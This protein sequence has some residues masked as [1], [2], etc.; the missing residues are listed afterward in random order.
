MLPIIDKDEPVITPAINPLAIVLR[1]KPSE[2]ICVFACCK[3]YSE[4]N[5]D[6]AAAPTVT[7]VASNL[8]TLIVSLTAKALL[9]VLIATKPLAANLP[10]PTPVAIPTGSVPAPINIIVGI[11]RNGL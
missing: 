6:V 7:A 4:V 2:D 1:Y 8:L 5:P 10:I 9:A 11:V 3:A